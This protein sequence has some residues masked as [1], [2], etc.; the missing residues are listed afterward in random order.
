MNVSFEN[1]VFLGGANITQI[2]DINMTNF[3]ENAIKINERQD[4]P[5]LNMTGPL[6][7]GNVTVGLLNGAN[8]SDSVLV[9]ADGQMANV[10]GHW[11]MKNNVSIEGELVVEGMANGLD[12]KTLCSMTTDSK[13]VKL[14]VGGTPLY[15]L[16]VLR[17]TIGRYL[18]SL[19]T[20]SLLYWGKLS[21]RKGLSKL[22]FPIYECVREREDC[23]SES[24]ISPEGR[25]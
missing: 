22:C 15:C 5:S 10:T 9:K 19:L 2:N 20:F 24:K 13:Q 8:F 17:K 18:T 16:A 11:L 12:W 7:F 21:I 3:K 6:V 1:A 14:L 4:L 23:A 25:S